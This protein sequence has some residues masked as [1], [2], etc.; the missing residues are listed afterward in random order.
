MNVL[1]QQ[2]FLSVV[3]VHLNNTLIERMTV[4]NIKLQLP[5]CIGAQT[6]KFDIW[7]SQAQNGKNIHCATQGASL[8]INQ[9]RP[10]GAIVCTI[11]RQFQVI[12]QNTGPALDSVQYDVHLDNA[13]FGILDPTDTIVFVSDFITLPA[14]GFYT[15]PVTGYL[16][17]SNRDPSSGLPLIVEV[18]VPLRPNTT[19]ATMENGCGPLPL[20]FISFTAQQ[21]KNK[22]LLNWQTAGELNNR[23]FDVQRKLPGE[24]FKTI[25]FVPSRSAN[26]NQLTDYNFE[27]AGT[28]N[29]AC[30][31]FY[32]LKQVDQDGSF[33]LTEVRLVNYNLE[34]TS[35]LI[36]P[37]PARGLA[38]IILPTGL[39]PVDIVL[40][41]VT[42][43]EVS[44]WNGVVDQL[45]MD[46][47]N[48]GAYV[49]RILVRKAGTVE[50]HKMLVL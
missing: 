11:P 12:I 21:V 42:G 4:K 26:G 34:N 27:D 5:S 47:L 20:K 44:R 1:P 23:G 16:P 41:D 30:Q 24:D 33:S 17:Y 15:S 48:A 46:N 2:S 18:T 7:A 43:K 49:L 37:N 39:G 14:D 38:R 6:L 35:I 10:V 19:T 8:V 13:P 25:G 9:V 22:V 45:L 29:K 31:V 3:K 32:R 36:Y 50:A 40:H 28:L